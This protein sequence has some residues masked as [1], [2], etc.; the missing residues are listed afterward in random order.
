V[1]EACDRL[2]RALVTYEEIDARFDQAITHLD[3]CG[4]HRA[5]GRSAEARRHAER[6]AELLGTLPA[7]RYRRRAEETLAK[8]AGAAL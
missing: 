3:L 8:L 6:A 2:G 4:V 1:S 5:A 7:P